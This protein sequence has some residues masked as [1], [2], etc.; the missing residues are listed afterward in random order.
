M[1]Q[2]SGAE[3]AAPGQINK[4]ERIPLEDFVVKLKG[5]AKN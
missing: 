3:T 1:V 2:D 4:A 5:Y